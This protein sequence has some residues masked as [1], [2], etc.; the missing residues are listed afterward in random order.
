MIRLNYLEAIEQI[1]KADLVQRIWK[2]VDSG[3]FPDEE[4]VTKLRTTQKTIDNQEHEI[5]FWTVIGF[6]KTEL[7]SMASEETLKSIEPEMA[8]LKDIFRQLED[9]K[10][11][12]AKLKEIG[13][14]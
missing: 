3:F 2:K 7:L 11:V 9:R 12:D 13:L 10:T 1:A 14:R 5:G 8:E 6:I 4:I